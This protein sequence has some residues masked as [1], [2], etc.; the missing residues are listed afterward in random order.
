M[1]IYMHIDGVKGSVTA[2]GHKEWIEL[3]S[4]EMSADRKITNATGHGVNREASVASMD[5]IRINKNLDCASTS[6]LRLAMM[7]EGKTVKIH[8]CKT[9]QKGFA[10]YLELV[11]ENTLVSSFNLNGV[12]GLDSPHPDEWMALNFTKMTFATNQMTEKN[13][14]GKPERFMWDLAQGKGG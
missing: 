10:P 11:L 4:C 8:F 3:D 13:A 5:E 12:G 14:T 6:L 1:P 2:E 7:G 9:D